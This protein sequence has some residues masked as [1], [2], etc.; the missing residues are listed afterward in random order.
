MTNFQKVV[1]LLAAIVAIALI[2][3]PPLGVYHGK[4]F[5]ADEPNYGGAFQ[6]RFL[7]L[8]IVAAVI[9]WGIPNVRSSLKRAGVT[10]EQMIIAGLALTALAVAGYYF[11]PTM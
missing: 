11:W 6:V 1:I 9:G 10:D 5:N 2:F 3:N 4:S 8:A 7:A